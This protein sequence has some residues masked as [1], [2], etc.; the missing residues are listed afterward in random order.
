MGGAGSQVATRVDRLRFGALLW[1]QVVW[2]E[3]STQDEQWLPLQ[4]LF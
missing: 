4:P 3:G 1:L 2:Q